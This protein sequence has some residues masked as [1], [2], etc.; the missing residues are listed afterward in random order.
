ME[1]DLPPL[2]LAINRISVGFI[3]VS[4]LITMM[5]CI[6]TVIDDH[7]GPVIG[8]IVFNFITVVAVVFLGSRCFI[9]K[10]GERVMEPIML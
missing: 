5:F 4:S 3:F 1:P 9:R 10:N 8:A 7:G 2:A 6:W